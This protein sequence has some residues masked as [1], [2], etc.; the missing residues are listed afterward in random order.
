MERLGTVLRVERHQQRSTRLIGFAEDEKE[1]IKIN[2]FSK[3]RV[4]AKESKTMLCDQETQMVNRYQTHFI[5]G[6][7]LFIVEITADL[8]Y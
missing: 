7:C 5:F 1:E 6:L 3:I 8:L 2:K 4:D